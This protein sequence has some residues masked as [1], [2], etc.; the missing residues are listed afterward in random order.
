MSENESTEASSLSSLY[1][2]EV[3]VLIIKEQVF[4]DYQI[5]FWPTFV[6]LNKSFVIQNVTPI[7]IF[8]ILGIKT[9]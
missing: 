2:T 3:T 7:P 6:H 8:V 1:K 4:Y 5:Y 9:A